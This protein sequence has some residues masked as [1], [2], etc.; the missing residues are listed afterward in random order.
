[1]E[2]KGSLTITTAHDAGVISVKIRDTGPGIPP[3]NI[4]KLF[5]PFF[6]TKE[7]GTGLGLAISYGIV[8]RHSGQIDVE[9]ELGKGSTFII[10]LPVNTDGTGILSQA[11]GLAANQN[12]NTGRR[13]HGTKKNSNH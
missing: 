2:G 8:E 9:T 5:N 10:T 13:N 1:M 7:K 11:K 12:I 6:T 4:G 3:E